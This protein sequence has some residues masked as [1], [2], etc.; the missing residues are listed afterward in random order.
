MCIQQ[1][2]LQT[3]F[4]SLVLQHQRSAVSHLS[5]PPL[6]LILF[7][8]LR[9]LKAEVRASSPL[10]R[11]GQDYGS[12]FGLSFSCQGHGPAAGSPSLQ[13]TAAVAHPSAPPS[14]VSGVSAT[15]C[16][17]RCRQDGGFVSS[18]SVFAATQLRT[19]LGR[20]FYSTSLRHV[21]CTRI[22]AP[23]SA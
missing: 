21:Q 16:C 23:L 4:S 3:C 1:E 19:D 8:L 9:P 12:V 15:Q 14:G 22:C 17:V 2:E 18:L 13:Q 10:S 7:R 5:A 11:R 6:H 20:H